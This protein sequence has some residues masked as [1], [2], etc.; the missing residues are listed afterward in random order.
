MLKSN[1]LNVNENS[2]DIKSIRKIEK[3]INIPIPIVDELDHHT[4]G[5]EYDGSSIIKLN[6]FN[7][8]LFDIPKLIENLNKL[9]TLDL[10]HNYIK[11]IP[12]FI[13]SLKSLESLDIRY[14]KIMK[15][16]EQKYEKHN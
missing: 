10:S 4:F 12:N 6:L 16:E 13:G 3:L 2:N 11:S 15:K 14:N 1:N 7:C 5:A 8:S 9:I